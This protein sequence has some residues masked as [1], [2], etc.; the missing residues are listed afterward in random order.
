MATQVGFLAAYDYELLLHS[1]PRI[2]EHADEIFICIDRS[3]K[4]WSGEKFDILPFFFDQLKAI[5]ASGK[6]VIYEE[7]FYDAARTPMENDTHQRNRLAQRMGDGQWCIQ[8]D[9]DEYFID[10]PHF[11]NRLKGIQTTKPVTVKCGALSVFKEVEGGFLCID[12]YDDVMALAT[13]RRTFERSRLHSGNEELILGDCFIVH[14]SWAR[15]EEEVYQKLSNWSHRDDFH[16]DSYFKL[17]QA[18]DKNNFRYMNDFHPIRRGMWNSLEFVPAESIE[19]LVAAAPDVI[20]KMRA[21]KS[22]WKQLRKRIRKKI[23]RAS[24]GKKRPRVI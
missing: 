5:D 20:R 1:I 3:R 6:I 9:S 23:K 10:F 13:N 14:Q 24:L 19:D 16:I 21:R 8:V 7:D 2:Y 12:D 17:W 15:S 18:V 22:G 4:T 11:L